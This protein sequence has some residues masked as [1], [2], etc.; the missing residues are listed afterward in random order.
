MLGAGL[1]VVGGVVGLAPTLAARAG[2]ATDLAFVPTEPAASPA[3]PE[4]GW[5]PDP[6]GQARLRYWDGR[7]WSTQTQQ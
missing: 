6:S 5:Y 3:A 7:A 2:E 1:V 4:P